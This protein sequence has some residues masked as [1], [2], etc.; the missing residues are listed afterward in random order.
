MS[1]LEFEGPSL[2]IRETC[3]MC[4]YLHKQM[5][6]S[7]RHPIY[8]YCC[9]H[10]KADYIPAPFVPP[11][12]GRYIGQDPYTPSWCPLSRKNS[13]SVESATTDSQQR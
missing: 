1:I 6:C 10:G 8:E 12:N 4:K 3:S 2:S 9:K 7:G 11:E 5:L 13:D